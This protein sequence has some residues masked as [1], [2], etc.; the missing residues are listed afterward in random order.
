MFSAQQGKKLWK[1]MR[2]DYGG[3]IYENYYLLVDE[4]KRVFR[5]NG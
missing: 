3:G 5:F 4:E 1:S 2:K